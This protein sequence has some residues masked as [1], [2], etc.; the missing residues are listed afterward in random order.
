MDWNNLQLDGTCEEI[1]PPLSLAKKFEAF[2][3]E[4]YECDGN[5]MAQLVE[6]MDKAL[7][8]KNGLPK[9]IVG[10]TDGDPKKDGVMR[11]EVG[12][13]TM[14]LSRDGFTF[15]GE[16]NG[17]E[18]HISLLGKDCPGALP[19]SV[20]DHFDVYFGGYLHFFTPVPDARD[21]VKFVA[22]KDSLAERE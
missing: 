5:D 21:S 9:C 1:M 10:K 6:V 13:G 15:D 14:S 2:G 7:A 19:I 22:Y 12:K 17:E 11:R 8:S 4:V 18:T 3:F 16:I 20:G